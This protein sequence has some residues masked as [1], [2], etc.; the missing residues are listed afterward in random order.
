VSGWLSSKDD[1][2]APWRVLQPRTAEIFALR[3]ELD[4]LLRLSGGMTNVEGNKVWHKV[5]SE[6]TERVGLD[7][8]EEVLWPLQALQI[9]EQVVDNPF[10]VALAR[11]DMVGVVLA[12]AL[13]KGALG[14]RPVCLVGYSLGARVIYSCLQ[15]LAARR[16]FDIVESVVL[17]GAPCPSDDRLWRVMR[18]VVSGRLINA[19]SKRDMLLALV[20]RVLG[21]QWGIAGIQ[22][23]KGVKGVENVDVGA[24]V[25]VHTQYR[26]VVGQ[27]LLQVGWEG[28]DKDKI[29]ED[30]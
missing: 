20:Y 1:I 9:S 6:V 11:A 18:T 30:D 3:W 8:L 17:M 29:E 19:Y 14:K 25:T 12:D 21:V 13:G 24:L 15:E 23:V 7:G 28:V 5:T 16:Q 10:N 2:T 4:A 26:D 27:I 22:E